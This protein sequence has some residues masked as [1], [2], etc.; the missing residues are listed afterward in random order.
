MKVKSFLPINQIVLMMMNKQITSLDVKWIFSKTWLFSLF[1]GY[2]YVICLFGFEKLRKIGLLFSTTM[3]SFITIDPFS[4]AFNILN[5]FSILFYLHDFQNFWINFIS[6]NYLSYSTR[7]FFVISIVICSLSL[8]GYSLYCGHKIETN[9]ITLFS[10]KIQKEITFVHISDVHIGSRFVEHSKNIVD[11]ILPL[12]PDFVVITGDLIDSPNVQKEELVPFKELA[13]QCPIYMS[14]GN[15]DYFMEMNK[16]K[17]ILDHSGIQLLQNEIT[18]NETLNYSVIGTNDSKAN[19]YIQ[20]MNS[21]SNN[22]SKN[23]YNIILQHRPHGWKETCENGMYDL[24]LSG[25]THVGQFA[26]FNKLVYLFFEKAYGLYTIQE[27][28]NEMRL[29][30]HPGTGA[31]GPHMRSAGPNEIT[32]FHIKPCINEEQIE[33]Q[34]N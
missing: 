13:K 5:I 34:Q 15:H 30:T 3:F 29:Y 11:K 9:K 33:I 32:I 8:F 17:P 1:L 18:T 22:C 23:T 7:L 27:G 4:I 20:T 26:P 31:W 16:L 24:M 12:K 2:G 10:S 14:T 21:L 6:C 19:K 25:H 28:G